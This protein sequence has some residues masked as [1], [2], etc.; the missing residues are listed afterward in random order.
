MLMGFCGGADLHDFYPT[1]QFTYLEYQRMLKELLN[2]I[3][4]LYSKSSCN[5]TSGVPAAGQRSRHCSH[6][7]GFV[8][9]AGRLS[10]MQEDACRIL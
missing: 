1:P 6:I 5:A 4:S 8:W 7:G 3:V 2:G 10:N 9:E